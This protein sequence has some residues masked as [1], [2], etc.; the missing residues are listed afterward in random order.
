M[1]LKSMQNENIIIN[2][3]YVPNQCGVCH[4]NSLSEITT[5]TYLNPTLQEIPI[6]FYLCK[7]CACVF[8]ND[9]NFLPYNYYKYS[10]FNN[11]IRIASLSKSFDFIHC[12]LKYRH[13]NP[14]VL[15]IGC[16]NG[17]LMLLLQ[18]YVYK[19]HGIEQS[20]N[21][22]NESYNRGLYVY[23]SLQDIKKN[24]YDL[25]IFNHVIEH[26]SAPTDFIAEYI[27]LLKSDGAIFIEVPSIE[28]LA[29]GY[30]SIYNNLYPHHI[31]H[32][33]ENSICKLAQI[34]ELSINAI[35]HHHY[36]NYP[37]MMCF[38]YKI[39]PYQH[40][41]SRFNNHV[42]YEKTKV[43][44]MVNELE[45]HATSWSDLVIWGCSDEAYQILKNLTSELKSKTILV[46]SSNDKIGKRILML[47][48]KSPAC[49]KDLDNILFFIAPTSPIIVE[50]IKKSIL[51]F[52]EGKQYNIVLN[53]RNL[54]EQ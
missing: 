26:L 9:L 43:K 16:T 53:S 39:P 47:K 21:A 12:F 27:P 46:D 37:S 49:L 45:K 11:P 29:R 38:L 8:H 19:V 33:S 24:Q 42:E 28:K 52:A 22:R 23:E 18:S 44:N 50:S 41:L 6:R 15:D 54:A 2:N 51:E 14:T 48:V 10:Y 7:D 17:N 25:L 35:E 3:F 4:G 36:F 5:L 13:L 30:Q 20:I 31:Y 32:F 40:L 34:L 1:R